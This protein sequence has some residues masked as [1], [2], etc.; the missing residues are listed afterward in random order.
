[1]RT[2]A[3][4]GIVTVFMISRMTLMAAMRATPP[5]LRMSEGTRSRAITAHAPAFSAMRACSALVTS[6]MTP[7]LS[8]S[9]S[10]TFTRHSFEPLALP[11]WP[12]P[13]PF[14]FFACISLLL[15]EIRYNSNL[16]LH[17]AH[18]FKVFFVNG[19][20][21]PGAAR[22]QIALRVANLAHAK[23]IPSLL[24]LLPAFH[25]NFAAHGDGLAVF[26]VQLG[27]DG[28]FLRQFRKLAHG[29]IEH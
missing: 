12:L 26:D 24:F 8:I 3:I 28:V 23:T 13:L 4:T 16:L 11:L 10:P 27:G 22:E 2:L 29:L 6:M 14:G 7:P 17:R 18:A 5:S 25:Y 15:F 20:E 21:A 9:A 19:D 1:M